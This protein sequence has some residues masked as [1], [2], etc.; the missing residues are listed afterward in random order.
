MKVGVAGLG[1]IGG[2]LL[3]GLGDAVG[4]DADPDV[5][6]AAAAEGFEVVDSPDRLAGCELV[7]VA[8]PPAAHLRRRRRRPRRRAGRGGGRH[9]VRQGRGCRSAI[10]F[11]SAHPMAGS[12]GSGWAASSAGLLQG[13]VW[14]VCPAGPR[15]SRRA[16]WRS[17]STGSAGG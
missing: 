5:R 17:P 8:V 14:A 11:V 10:A 16:G 1:L 3:R 12:E 7:L 2:S 13:A 4:Y 6:S 15:S 9:G